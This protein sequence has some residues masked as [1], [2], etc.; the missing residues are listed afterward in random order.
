MTSSAAVD[1]AMIFSIFI[2]LWG[3]G[4]AM[5]SRG[6]DQHEARQPVFFAS[7]VPLMLSVAALILS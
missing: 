7:I 5:S 4:F 3:F 2:F 1:L 6:I